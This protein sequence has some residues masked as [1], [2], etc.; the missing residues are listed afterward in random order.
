MTTPT[1]ATIAAPAAVPAAPRFGRVA[2][3]PVERR[4]I[5][6][7]L[8]TA[9]DHLGPRRP[10]FVV[11]H[12][13]L[14]TLAGT[15]RYF[16][17]DARHRART[18]YG[19]D[20]VTGAVWRWTDPLGPH[21]PWASGPF[22]DPTPLGRALVARFGLATVNRD[23]VSI[24]VSGG[25]HDPVSEA[26][27][28]SLARLVA[29]WA[30]W[31]G[32]PHDRWPINPQSAERFVARHEDFA[33]KACPFAA[34]RGLVPEV[35]R[36]AGAILRAAQSGDGASPAPARPVPPTPSPGDPGGSAPPPSPPTGLVLP[37]GVTVA[38]LRDWFGRVTSNGDRALSFGFDPAG[39]VSRRWLA[40]GHATGAWPELLAVRERDG[41]R[42]FRFDGGYTLVGLPDGTVAEVA[43]DRAEPRAGEG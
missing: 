42:L 25:E 40:R 21:A 41:V 29:F 13:M 3:P 19:V 2:P 35:E 24:E 18:D 5:P 17:T 20:H 22:D 31:A 9:W 26:A 37:P 4:D 6:P 33:A 7:D 39:P 11:L 30:D 14:G 28:G 34:L 32:V 10:R 8:N 15:D 43:G 27:L 23:G 38:D 12:R 1:T 16:R 36:R